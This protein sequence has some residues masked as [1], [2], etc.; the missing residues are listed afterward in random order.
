[1]S[2]SVPFW[3]LFA[4]SNYKLLSYLLL[5]PVSLPNWFSQDV[6]RELPIKNCNINSRPP[7]PPPPNFLHR[8]SLSLSLSLSLY[9]SL[10]L[11]LSVSLSLSLS[12]RPEPEGFNNVLKRPRPHGNRGRMSMMGKMFSLGM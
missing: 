6:R 4:L 10:S 3:I 11:S 1:M 9:L 7:L 8:N 5:S 12:L 2:L